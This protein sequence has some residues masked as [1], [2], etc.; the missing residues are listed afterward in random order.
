MTPAAI[1]D[2]RNC[3]FSLWIPY[4]WDVKGLMFNLV[5]LTFNCINTLLPRLPIYQ[6]VDYFFKVLIIV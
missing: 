6:S 2:D 3:G 5:V 4:D 1:L